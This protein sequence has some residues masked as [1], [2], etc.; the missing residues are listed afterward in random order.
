MNNPII[1]TEIE[2]VIKKSPKKTQK[3][4]TRWLYRRIL[5]NIQRRANVY[6][7]KSLSKTLRGRET[8]KLILRGQNQT[9]TTQKTK[10]THQY[11]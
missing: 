4:R 9:K 2:A 10:T 5:S 6:P 1:T 3:P 7:S 11:H 8:S